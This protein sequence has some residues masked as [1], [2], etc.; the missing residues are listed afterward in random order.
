VK[1]KIDRTCLPNW[2][3]TFAALGYEADTV[4][5]EGL[6]GAADTAVLDAAFAA[7]RILLTLDKGIANLQRY[8]APQHAGVVLF[9]PDTSGR[10]AVITFVRERLQAVLEIDLTNRLT[11][12]GPSRIRD[13]CGFSLAGNRTNYVR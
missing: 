5:D 10:E 13:R 4:H 11:V 1:F 2:P 7:D 9:R 3:R 8:P 6:Q 12:V